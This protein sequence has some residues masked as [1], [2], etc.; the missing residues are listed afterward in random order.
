MTTMMKRVMGIGATTIALSALAATP[1]LAQGT[2]DKPA[3]PPTVPVKVEVVIS[4][5]QGEKKISSQ[6]YVLMPTAD[7]R[8]GGFTTL[9]VGVDVPVGVNTTI[10]PPEGGREGATTTQPQY[11]NIGTNI[12]CGVTS[13]ADGRF[14]VRVAVT[15]TSIFNPDAPGKPAKPS[16]NASISSFVANN[17]LTL[18]DGQM[19]NLIT[20]TDKVTGELIKVDVTLTVL[21]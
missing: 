19:L 11:K 7:P 14:S 2:Q 3:P 4:R 18:R 6:P 10:K 13:M 16:E 5:F 20:A 1:A 21:K 8:G 12:D 9:R 15:D 17:T